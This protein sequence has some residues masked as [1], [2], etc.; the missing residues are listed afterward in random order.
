MHVVQSYPVQPEDNQ[1]VWLVEGLADYARFKY[2]RDNKDWTL[3]D[4]QAGVQK[5]TDSYK[6]TA[7]FLVWLENK[8]NDKIVNELDLALRENRYQ[9]G[10]IWHEKTQKSVDDLWNDYS[11]NSDL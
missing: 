10:Q 1:P 11:N 4:F 8:V 6:V 5:Y 3:P 9:N 7:R 2:A